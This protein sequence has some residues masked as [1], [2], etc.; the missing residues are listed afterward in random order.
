MEENKD[1]ESSSHVRL[2][3]SDEAKS[4]SSKDKLKGT[5]SQATK[6]KNLE[7]IKTVSFVQPTRDPSGTAEDIVA[8]TQSKSATAQ[9]SV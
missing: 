7:D 3:N 9:N 8:V 4:T 2:R 6:H 1:D 5:E